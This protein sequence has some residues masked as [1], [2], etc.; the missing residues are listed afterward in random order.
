MKNIFPKLLVIIMLLMSTVYA[1]EVNKKDLIDELNNLSYDQRM[2]LID[3]F[4]NTKESGNGLE[5]ILTSI[6]W[7][8]T[9][10]GD[11]FINFSDGKNSRYKGSYG[12]FQMLM[13]NYMRIMGYVGEEKA[14]RIAER[15]IS[16]REFA[17]SE[18]ERML[19]A[20][21]KHWKS[22]RVSNVLKSSIA[23]YNA[24]GWGTSSS[25]GNK[26]AEDV[27]IRAKVLKQ[28]LANT[29]LSGIHKI[30]KSTIS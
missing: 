7:K 17:R 13:N 16:D 5:Y 28:W 20:W 4:T 25:K 1:V 22:K 8:E 26:Y 19:I 3:T 30:N 21:Q 2:S 27:L 18:A 23:S 14:S 29:K 12:P 24:G 11:R 10:F 9:S 15:L 6:M